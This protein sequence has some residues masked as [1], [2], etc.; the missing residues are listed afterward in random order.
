MCTQCLLDQLG[1]KLA[2]GAVEVVD[3]SGAL[4]PDILLPPDFASN[5]PPPTG[6]IHIAAPLKT[7]NC[8]GSPIRALALVERG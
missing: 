2:S 8:A 7:R 3:L 6:T 5:T 4:G 1:A